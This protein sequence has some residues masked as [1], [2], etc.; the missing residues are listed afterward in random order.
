MAKKR[1]SSVQVVAKLQQIEVLT[2][3]GKALPLACKEAGITD[4]RYYHW[5]RDYNENRPH[6][7]IGYLTP[8]E[9]ARRCG[10][11]PVATNTREPEISTIDRS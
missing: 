1:F 3:G 5:R 7:A 9:F 8:A 4:V 11:E 6:S 2:S 10:F